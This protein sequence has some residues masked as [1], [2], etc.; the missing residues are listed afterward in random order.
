MVDRLIAS[1]LL[2]KTMT[3][4]KML[5]VAAA[6]RFLHRKYPGPS[7]SARIGL[8]WRHDGRSELDGLSLSDSGSDELRLRPGLGWHPKPNIDI[9]LSVDIP[10]LGR[11]TID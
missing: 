2:R 7:A 10:L 5:E 11:R 4:D 9:S 3:G 1:A 8:Q 6:Y